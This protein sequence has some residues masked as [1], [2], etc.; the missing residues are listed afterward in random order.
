MIIKAAELVHF[1]RVMDFYYDLINDMENAEFPPGWKKDIYPARQFIHDAIR[2]GDLYA[3]VEDSAIIGAMVINHDRPENYDK[4]SWKI[5]ADRNQ[6]A[7]IHALGV[8]AR[9][10]S[11]GI[12]KKMVARAVGICREKGLKAIRLDVLATNIPAQKLYTSMGF[13]YMG[14]LQLFYEDT[15][16]TDFYIYELPIE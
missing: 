5:N 11:R 10:Q 2:Q 6:A 16:L 12:G 3:A 9:R 13:L 8:S 1:D 7:F 4:V 15:G 14:T